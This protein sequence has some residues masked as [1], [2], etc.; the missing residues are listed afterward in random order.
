MI[1]R[2]YRIP[3]PKGYEPFDVYKLCQKICVKLGG[4]YSGSLGYP[5][6]K[7]K[8]RKSPRY[9]YPPGYVFK[10]RR[11]ALQA[12]KDIETALKKVKEYLTQNPIV[13]K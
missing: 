12:E 13:I 4:K 2:E 10:T 11:K 3:I 9:N 6:N 8:R 1:M 7:S 5:E